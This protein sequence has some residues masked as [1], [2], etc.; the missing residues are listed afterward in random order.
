VNDFL[1]TKISDREIQAQVLEKYLKHIIQSAVDAGEALDTLVLLYINSTYK[2]SLKTVVTKAKE[3]VAEM[4]KFKDENK[5]QD[6]INNYNMINYSNFTFTSEPVQI[7]ADEVKFDIKINSNKQLPCNIP[8]K[9]NISETYKTIGGWKLDFSSGIFF[10][11]GNEDFIGREL[12]YI[13]LD[14]STVTIQT[15]DGGK[16]LLLSL[17]ALM[18]IYY[19]REGSVNWAVSPGLSTTTAFDGIIF[20]LGGSA[21]FG[22]QNRIVLTAGISL[23]EAKVLDRNYHFDQHYATT[24]LP[25]NP[26]TI[27]VFPKSGYFVSLTYNWSKSTIQ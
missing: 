14:N 6:L 16:R 11:G 15:K 25:E 4:K 13:P 1:G 17:G 26:P 2:D 3:S 27:K 21:I 18:H 24:D 23:R 12:Q 5:I 7:K 22:W 8:S 10:N 20:H 19:R 9:T